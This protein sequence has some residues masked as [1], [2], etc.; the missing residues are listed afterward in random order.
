MAR[1]WPSPSPS[2]RCPPFLPFPSFLYTEEN[3]FSYGAA[4]SAMNLTGRGISLSARAYF[5][6]TTQRWARLAFPWIGG[7]HRSFDF[8][9]GERDRAD[10]MNG[11]EEDS[12]EFTPGVGTWL[13]R[14]GRLRV[15]PSLFQMKSDVDGK[16]LDPDNERRAGAPLGHDRLRHPGLVARSPQGLEERAGGDPHLG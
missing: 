7:N 3:G 9:G 12:W 6:G 5:G 1:G 13:G 2:R 14:H 15:A 4:L 11:F 16:T 8:F 10:T